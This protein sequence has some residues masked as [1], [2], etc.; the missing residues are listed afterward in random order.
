MTSSAEERDPARGT[1]RRDVERGPHPG[2]EALN[3]SDAERAE[4]REQLTQHV[5]VTDGFEY[6]REAG[7]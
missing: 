5:D 4:G 6:R 2:R 7:V 3:L 1:P